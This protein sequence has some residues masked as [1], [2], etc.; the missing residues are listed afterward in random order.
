M[1][2]KR[3]NGLKLPA[4][5]SKGARNRFSIA[6]KR[7]KT[8]NG[9]FDESSYS[10]TTAMMSYFGCLPARMRRPR[11]TTSAKALSSAKLPTICR[12]QGS[13]DFAT[14]ACRNSA[15]SFSTRASRL[16]S[17]FVVVDMLLIRPARR[18]K[19]RGIPNCRL[20]QS[21]P[22]ES[23][24]Y[25]TFLHSTPVKPFLIDTVYPTC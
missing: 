6:G 13:A 9:R 1:S 20:A 10:L 7:F 22:A 14:R 23:L 3:E 25:S 18:R 19:T 2:A 12:Y 15:N 24:A 8:G 4:G 21:E 11:R 16:S 5:K 17:C